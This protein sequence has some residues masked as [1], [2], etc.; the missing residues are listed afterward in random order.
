MPPCLIASED[1]PETLSWLA[2]ALSDGGSFLSYVARAGLH[3]DYQN[4]PLI[5][6]LILQ[7]RKRYPEFDPEGVARRVMEGRNPGQQLS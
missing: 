4:Y 2:S 1:T 6:P 3:A 7:L 5:R